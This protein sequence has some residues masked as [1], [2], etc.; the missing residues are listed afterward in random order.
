[1]YKKRLFFQLLSILII[2]GSAMVHADPYHH[3]GG[4]YNRGHGGYRGYQRGP[5]FGF[6]FGAPLYSRPY[7]PYPYQPY[8]P[9]TIVTVPVNPPVYIERSQPQPTQPLESGYWYYC[10][11]PEGY[12]PYVQDCPD[13]WRQV[14]PIPPR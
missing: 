13:G 9:P 11:N 3:R 14:D 1:M 12:Y 8:Y 6:Y 7:Y 10:S 2:C 5:S 4:Y